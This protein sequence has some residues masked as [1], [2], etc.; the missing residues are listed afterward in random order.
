VAQSPIG[1]AAAIG[2]TLLISIVTVY[3]FFLIKKKK[4]F[5]LIGLGGAILDVI[6]LFTLIVIWYQSLGGSDISI[7]IMMKSQVFSM[8][9][10]FLVIN[11]L[12]LRPLYPAVISFGSF[13]LQITLLIISLADNRTIVSSKLTEVYMGPAVSIEMYLSLVIGLLAIGCFLM[14]LTYTARKTIY[15][16]VSLERSNITIKEEQSRLVEQGKMYALNNLVASIAHELNNPIGAVTSAVDNSRRCVAK[17]IDIIDNSQSIDKLISN[18]IYQKSLKIL[19]NDTS[20]LRTATERIS[21]LIR[22]LKSFVH[23]DEA[24]IQEINICKNLDSVIMFLGNDLKE[25]ISIYR[26]YGRIPSFSCNPAE[27]NQVFMTL[28]TNAAQ[29]I[30]GKGSITIRTNLKE[31]H[32]NIQIKDTGIGIPAAKLNKLFDLSF[33]DDGT[34]VTTGLGLFTAHHIV[35]K[36]EG[37]IK[38]ATELGKGSTFTVILPVGKNI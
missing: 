37:G 5:R 24:N 28:I 29:A 7:S 9:F 25:K 27:I 14:F 26:E 10:I 34:R 17:I 4:K 19:K 30:K 11:S 2:L 3:F 23:L 20:V 31:D 36:H 18:S 21:K 15:E 22:N 13:S 35:S 6:F 16:A 12:A 8:T 32:I 38:V 1:R 33:S